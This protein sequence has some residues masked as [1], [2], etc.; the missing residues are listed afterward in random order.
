MENLEMRLGHFTKVPIAD[1]PG[2]RTGPGPTETME[3]R[4]NKLLADPEKSSLRTYL[5]R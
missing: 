5:L 4:L 3:Q 2:P 1:Y